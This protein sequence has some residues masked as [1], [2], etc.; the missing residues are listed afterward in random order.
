MFQFR[1]FCYIIVSLRGFGLSHNSFFGHVTS[2]DFLGSVWKR[3]IFWEAR[4]VKEAEPHPLV[5]QLG[6]G[7]WQCF[8]VF[9]MVASRRSCVMRQL[10]QTKQ[11]SSYRQMVE[12][13]T[14]Y[15]K[16][17]INEKKCT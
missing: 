7:C 5:A 14:H 12:S 16:I 17:I 3:L 4:M 2:I 8:V 1:H 6:V 9:A 15:L 10:R 11:L 13:R